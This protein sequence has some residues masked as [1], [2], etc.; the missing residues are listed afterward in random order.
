M[1][2]SMICLSYKKCLVS[3]ESLSWQEQIAETF[4]LRNLQSVM[5]NFL[6]S[7]V[8]PSLKL[9]RQSMVLVSFDFLRNN[10]ELLL[11]LVLNQ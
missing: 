4:V 8:S 11:Y 2:H 5:F 3:I 10:V 1:F 6:V 7:L 9:H